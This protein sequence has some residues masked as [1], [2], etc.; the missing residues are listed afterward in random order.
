M[1]HMDQKIG[2]F[3]FQPIFCENVMFFHNNIDVKIKFR[4]SLIVIDHQIDE[5]HHVLT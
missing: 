3:A 2:P 5:K 1:D 4:Y